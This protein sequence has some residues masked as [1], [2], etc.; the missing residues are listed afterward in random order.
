M[1]IAKHAQ[2]GRY[3]IQAHYFASDRKRMSARSKVYATIIEGYGTAHEKVRREVV[4]LTTGK[5]I[6]EIATVTTR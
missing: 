5:D 4:T 2:R 6:H 1:Y 3:T